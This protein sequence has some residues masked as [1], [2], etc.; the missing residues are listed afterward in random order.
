MW[1]TNAVHIHLRE[2]YMPHVPVS[3]IAL[4]QLRRTRN[5]VA[6]WYGEGARL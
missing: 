2:A 3:M 1:E 5:M 4:L 6:D